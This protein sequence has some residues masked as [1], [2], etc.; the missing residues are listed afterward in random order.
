MSYSPPCSERYNVKTVTC[1]PATVRGPDENSLCAGMQTYITCLQLW[2]CSL[3]CRRCLRT[4]VPTY[5]SVTTRAG[6]SIQVYC[7][8]LKITLPQKDLHSV[9][10]SVQHPKAIYVQINIFSWCLCQGG[11]K[12][13]RER[14]ISA[15]VQLVTWAKAFTAGSHIY[16]VK[17]WKETISLNVWRLGG[18]NLWPSTHYYFIQNVS[19]ISTT[20]CFLFLRGN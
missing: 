13:Q 20:L 11:N 12:D 2:C 19:N 7:Y 3:P 16:S 14:K 8:R 1:L 4:A 6:S 15:G 10:L 5:H 9:Q 18:H 17:V